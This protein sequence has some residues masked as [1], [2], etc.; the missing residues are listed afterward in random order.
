MPRFS[1][2]DF[3][4]IE[5][6]PT[7]PYSLRSKFDYLVNSSTNWKVK[8]ESINHETGEYRIIFQGTLDCQDTK[9]DQ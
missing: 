2:A 7:S 3:S 5:A 6:A 1:I 9:F 8:V 4:S